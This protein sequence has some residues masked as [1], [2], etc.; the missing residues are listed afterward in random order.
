MPLRVHGSWIRALHALTMTL[1]ALWLSAGCLPA[2]Q[3]DDLRIVYAPVLGKEFSAKGPVND[4]A[5]KAGYVDRSERSISADAKSHDRIGLAYRRTPHEVRAGVGAFTWGLEVARDRVRERQTR[6]ELTGETYLAD[7][8]LG[9]TWRVMPGW[10]VEQGVMAG[11]GR[12]RYN[13]NFPRFFRDTS[14]WNSSATGFAYEYGFALGTSYT[15][16][17]HAQIGI[18]VRHLVTRSNATFTGSRN[19]GGGDTQSVSWDTQ[20]EVKGIGIS[21]GVGYRF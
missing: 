6:V 9:W 10:H 5:P 11:M 8:F 17:E 13:L 14:T 2:M 1:A 20:I 7:L 19:I 16:S 15:W 18:D 21:A 12:S 4:V 3:L